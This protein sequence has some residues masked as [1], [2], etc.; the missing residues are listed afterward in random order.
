MISAAAR[1]WVLW[2]LIAVYAVV[3]VVADAFPRTFAS[4]LN[5]PLS[6]LIPLC[7]GLLHGALRYRATGIVVFLVLC[8]GISNI[9]ENVS[10]MTG[11]PFGHYHYT[12]VLGPKLFLV[13]LLIGPAY[14]G[15]GYLS[16]VLANV[17]LG[18]DR[19][20]DVLATILVPVVATFIM[21][22]WDVCLDPQSSTITKIWIW[23]QGGSYFGVPV[24]NYLGWCLT[25]FAF[26]MVFSLYRAWRPE[27]V[28]QPLP[29]GYWYQACALFA[30]MALDF[31]AGYLGQPNVAVTD[32]AGKVWQTGDIFGTAAIAS[33]FT[34]LF[35][36][37]ASFAVLLLRPAQPSY[38]QGREKTA[39]TDLEPVSIK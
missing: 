1:S 37:V 24:S 19:R 28:V 26:L 4:P 20:R 39:R 9:L 10:V 13:P 18:T 27:P 36:A 15:T 5:L 30:V 3:T 25:V 17:L 21:V 38:P 34:M 16:W 33:L 32:A 11:F 22:G 35:V 12:D 8:L 6:I 31:P 14:F 29:R 7:F 23:E 2:L